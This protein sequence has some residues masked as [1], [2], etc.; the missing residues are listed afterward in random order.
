MIDRPV[1]SLLLAGTELFSRSCHVPDPPEARG[2]Y[3]DNQHEAVVRGTPDAALNWVCHRRGIDVDAMDMNQFHT[4]PALGTDSRLSRQALLFRE[5]SG[6][7]KS[8]GACRRDDPQDMS[9][10]CG[11]ARYCYPDGHA[12]TV[13][14]RVHRQRHL[15]A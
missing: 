12:I 13:K 15:R 9:R 3:R 2:R 7:A 4:L 1:L 14:M 6:C 11:S 5:P 8:P 10:P